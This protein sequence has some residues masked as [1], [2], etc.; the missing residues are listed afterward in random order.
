MKTLRKRSTVSPS[1]S[2]TKQSHISDLRKQI[3]DQIYSHLENSEESWDDHLEITLDFWVL[4]ISLQREEFVTFRG[5]E[6]IAYL[7]I[8]TYR[9]K[10]RLEWE[11][12]LDDP[13]RHMDISLHRLLIASPFASKEVMS[14]LLGIQIDENTERLTK[15]GMLSA[16]HASKRI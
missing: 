7:I 1:V 16:I 3:K 9:I 6:S 11:L 8:E 4:S 14:C 10:K 5:I 12:S 2:Q 15:D 13:L